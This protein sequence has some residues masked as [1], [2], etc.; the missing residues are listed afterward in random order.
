[1]KNKTDV[2]RLL[3]PDPYYNDFTATF[4]DRLLAARKEAGLSQKL[5]ANK[6]GVKTKT[7]QF[8]EEDK[9]EPRANKLQMVSALLNVSMVWLMSGLGNGVEPPVTSSVSEE[10]L[11]R[12]IL[13]ELKAIRSAISRLDKNTSNLEKKILRKMKSRVK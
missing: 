9:S 10:S 4:G 6:L 1:M 8:W 12:E 5:L 13:A 3:A 7:V 11:P 2:D